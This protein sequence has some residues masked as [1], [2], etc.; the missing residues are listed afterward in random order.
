MPEGENDPTFETPERVALTKLKANH[1][2]EE[3][4]MKR[5]HHDIDFAVQV[6]GGLLVEKTMRRQ[7]ISYKALAEI[8]LG[9]LDSEQ[10][11]KVLEL[12]RKH[13]QNDEDDEK[14]E[15]MRAEDFIESIKEQLSDKE[16]IRVSKSNDFTVQKIG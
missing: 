12:Y 1:R 13:G 6:S 10:Q 5:K 7:S 8:A 2:D 9:M 4:K 3:E 11:N 16:T 15:E 14:V